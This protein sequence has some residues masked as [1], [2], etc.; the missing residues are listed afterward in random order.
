MKIVIKGSNL[1][2]TPAL[3]EYVEEK[4]GRLTKYYGGITGAEVELVFQNNKSA[5][6]S[7]RVEVTLNAN[8]SI[9]RCQEASISMYASIDIASEKLERQ[10]RRLKQRHTD[11]GRAEK[12]TSRRAEEPEEQMPVLPER[13]SEVVKTKRF[14]VKPMVPNE[15][16]LQMEMLNHSF[17]VFLNPDTD[18][19]NVIYKRGDGDYGLIEPDFE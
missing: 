13:E 7:Q 17:Y 3:R 15:A 9:V 6:E 16:A 12:R 4:I 8:G 1:R 19:V 10:L 11:K 5:E 2:V 18:Q 14:A